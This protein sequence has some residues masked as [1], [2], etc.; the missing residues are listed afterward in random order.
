M[1][2]QQDIYVAGSKSHPPMLNN[3]NYVPWS[4][5]LFPYA[6]RKPNGKLLVNF[7]LHGPYKEAK[8]MEYDDQAIQTI[9][10]GLPEDIYATVDSC[11]TTQEIWLCVE[12]MMKGYDIG[13]QEKKAKLFNEWYKFNS[14]DEESIESYCHR[15]A[16]LITIFPEISIYQ[17]GNGMS[18]LF[19][20][21]RIWN[22]NRYNSVQNARN[23]VVQNTIQNLGIQ[24]VGNQNR[25]I[26]VLGIANHNANQNRNGNVVAAWAE[27]NG[28]G[29]ND[30]QIRC[31]K[32]RGVRHYARNC[33]AETIATAC[34]TQNRS[35]I[36]KRITKAPYELI[37][38]K[39]LDI[40]FYMYSRLSV[41]PRM[42]M[43]ILGS[44]IKK[45]I[46][47]MNVTFDELSA[48]AFEQHSSKP[49]LR[50]DVKMCIYALSVSTMEP[51]NVKEAMTDT[52]WIKAI[53]DEES[54]V[55]RNKARMV[56]RG[57]RQD[58]EIDFK[59]SFALVDRMEAIKIFLDYIAH[60]LFIVY[61]MDVKS[62][63][64]HCWLK[65]KVY[66]MSLEGFIDADHPSHVYKL[67][68]ELYGLKQVPKTWYDELLKFI[69]HNHSTNGT[70]DP[71][72]F[73]RR[74]DDDILVN[75]YYRCYLLMCSVPGSANREA[76]Q[77][78]HV[79]CH[80]T[81]KS[82]SGG[83]QILGKKLVRWSLKKQD[84][85]ALSTAEA[86]YVSLST[87]YAQ[88]L[89]MRTQLT[90][91]G[92]YLDKIPIYYDSKSAIAIS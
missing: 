80:D 92:F 39:K 50:T 78:D 4:S 89:W 16:K 76:P 22:Q 66:V 48:M 2:T 58:E 75:G 87:C 11:D 29:N 7:I 38:E 32:C 12:Q 10:M 14:T 60:K 43:R 5:R 88:V 61:Q 55:I 18:L 64:L 28:N 25:L 34:Y 49:E 85:T 24:N 47:T 45:I 86:E 63:F 8:Q 82:T 44:L 26:V 51:R 53:Q 77:G 68:K 41:I 19:I 36:H 6:K 81:F 71:T 21:R 83:T 57:Y 69:L 72:L 91:Y 73:T 42:I 17:N 30:N 84:C 59:E 65:E 35:L 67:K 40:S 3:E 56:M 62:I 54:M 37:N 74:Y 52:A 79:G 20:K 46:E 9:L 90:D 23:Q 1:S 33:T 27:G 70:V 13:A 15:F 31:Y